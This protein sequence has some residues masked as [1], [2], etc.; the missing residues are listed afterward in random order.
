VRE[1]IEAK[2]TDWRTGLQQLETRYMEL[3]A[4]IQ[5]QQGAIAGAEELLA[6]LDA[7][8]TPTAVPEGATPDEQAAPNA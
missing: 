7:A 2:L 5:R 8:E 6:A 1:Q 4:A 3:A